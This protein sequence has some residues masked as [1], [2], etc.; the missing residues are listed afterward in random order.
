MAVVHGSTVLDGLQTT[1]ACQVLMVTALSTC[2]FRKMSLSCIVSTKACRPRKLGK[3]DSPPE[4]ESE[5][6]R[7]DHVHSASLAYKEGSVCMSGT[8]AEWL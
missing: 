6:E 7:F 4:R 3:G 5:K 8:D 1:A 2:R